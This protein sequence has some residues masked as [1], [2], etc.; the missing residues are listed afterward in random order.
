MLRAIGAPEPQD[1]R[2][3]PAARFA[4]LCFTAVLYSLYPLAVCVAIAAGRPR[5]A[6]A[7]T[8]VALGAS[9]VATPRWRRLGIAMLVAAPFVVLSATADLAQ[10][11]VFLPP[12]ALNLGL[13]ALFARTLKRGR[14][15]LIST[16]ARA[17]RGTLE[18]DL[19]RYT[20]RLTALWVAFFVGAAAVSAL[21]ALLATPALWGWFV[22][23]GNHVAVALLFTGEYL[24]RRWRFPQYRHASPL[25]LAAIVVARWR[26]AGSSR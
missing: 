20:R 25:A 6:L 24:F 16:F 7:A 21:L 9:F 5:L 22:A 18:P 8:C 23:V 1:G 3:R 19:A 15:P 14:E 12:V 4:A 2:A 11:L 17:E 10:P 26:K 13:A